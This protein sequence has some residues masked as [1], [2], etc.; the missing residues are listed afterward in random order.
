[1]NCVNQQKRLHANYAKQ[2][3]F[4]CYS[5]SQTILK[6]VNFQLKVHSKIDSLHT[7]M[8]SDNEKCEELHK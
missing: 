8:Y 7:I 2:I 5:K 3:G 4:Q 6:Y 1:M